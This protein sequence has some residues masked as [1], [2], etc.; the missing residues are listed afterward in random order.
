M[1]YK[2]K[3]TIRYHDLDRNEEVIKEKMVDPYMRLMNL[4]TEYPSFEA[5]PGIR[6]FNKGSPLIPSDR[7]LAD[8]D[9]NP[10]DEIEVRYFIRLYFRDPRLR[11]TVIPYWMWVSED[12]GFTM[13]RFKE[14]FRLQWY[15]SLPPEP[16]FNFPTLGWLDHDN[17]KWYVMG[18]RHNDSV[19]IENWGPKNE[20]VPDKEWASYDLLREP[21]PPPEQPSFTTF[22][23]AHPTIYGTYRW[24]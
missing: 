2:M 18:V 20:R 14:Y 8:L 9:V 19:Y 7:T 1:S 24:D 17:K 6:L 4:Y 16:R 21:P 12:V 10:G 23:R 15:E 13:K 3:I 22:A 11:E 5:A